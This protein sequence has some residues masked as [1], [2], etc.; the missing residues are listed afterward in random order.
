[1]S[2]TVDSRCIGDERARR[3]HCERTADHAHSHHTSRLDRRRDA[4][5]S[6]GILAALLPQPFITY[7]CANTLCPRAVSD[8]FSGRYVVLVMALVVT[9]V[10]GFMSVVTMAD[11]RRKHQS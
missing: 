5:G 8:G 6:R 7:A 9:V 1:V 2:P 10:A 3:I 11:R 4:P